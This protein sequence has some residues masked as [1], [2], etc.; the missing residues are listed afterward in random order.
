MKKWCHMSLKSD[1]LYLLHLFDQQQ[2]W[3]KEKTE[4]D[5]FG[6]GDIC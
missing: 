2:N 1:N 5:L 6:S 3:S 4:S